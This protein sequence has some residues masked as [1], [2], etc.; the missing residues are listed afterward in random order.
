MLNP[1][2]NAFYTPEIELESGKPSRDF[3]FSSKT[4]AYQIIECR[5]VERH[6]REFLKK[7]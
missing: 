5:I 4:G 1:D 2:L 3:K 7:I 6:L